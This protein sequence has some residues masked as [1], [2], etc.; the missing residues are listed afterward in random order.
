[1]NIEQPHA[2]PNVRKYTYTKD[3]DVAREKGYIYY[4][5][6]FCGT[7]INIPYDTTNGFELG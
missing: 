3:A 1:M 4:P 2:F 6:Y 7:Y 5:N